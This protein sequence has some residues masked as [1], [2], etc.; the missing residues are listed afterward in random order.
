MDGMTM[1]MEAFYI[2]HGI[3]SIIFIYGFFFGSTTIIV[4]ENFVFGFLLLLASLTA[5]LS[6]DT[7]AT[8][9]FM[10]NYDLLMKLLL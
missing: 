4:V 10:A 5:V 3:L 2:Y 6:V 7:E 8:I 1:T 9:E